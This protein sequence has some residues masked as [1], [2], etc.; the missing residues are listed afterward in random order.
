MDRIIGSTALPTKTFVIPALLRVLL[1]TNPK[2]T[3]HNTF[4]QER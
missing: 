3:G 4:L 1:A 2:P